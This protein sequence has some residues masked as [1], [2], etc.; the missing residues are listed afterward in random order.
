VIAN[1]STLEDLTTPL[2][3]LS[4]NTASGSR[5]LVL[6]DRCDGGADLRTTFDNIPQ[7]DGQLN[8][9]Q[10]MTGYKMRLAIALWD[11]DDPACG[12]AA[13]GMLDEL[14]AHIDALRN[15]TGT[16][17][18][19]WTPEGYA[20]RM[21]N[22]INL[23]EKPVVTVEPGGA[24]GIVTVTFAVVSPFPYEMSEA[25][26]TP[27]TI[28]DGATETLVNSGSTRFW[29]VFRV[30]GPTSAFT[31]SNDTTGE[32]I[33]YNGTTIGAMHYAEIDCFRGTVYLDGNSSNLL[34]GINFELT[35]FF[36]LIV[37]E[38]DVTINGADCTVLWNDSWL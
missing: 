15:P 37:N 35:D 14:G 29:P 38:N 23:M 9:T 33:I 1:W 11:G 28:A 34:D 27:A 17:R 2:G 5:Y 6:N 21:I 16:T 19:V 26:E 24:E 22:E 30:N 25:E 8:H 7:S 12:Q 3:T 13:Q 31:I 10:Y 4:L 32:E 36:P 18:I 20:S